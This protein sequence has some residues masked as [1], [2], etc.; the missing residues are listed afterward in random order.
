MIYF[1]KGG[2]KIRNMQESDI[3]A[4]SDEEI[5]Q[6]WSDTS[7]KYKMRIRDQ[8]AG[9]CVA[10]AAEFGGKIAGYINLYRNSEY[11]PFANHGIPEIIDFG[12]LEK[13]RRNGIGTALMDTAEKI[14]FSFSDLVCLCVGLHG[15]YGS[16]Q[17][18]YVKRGF[19]PDGSGVWYKDAPCKQN[20]IYRND[21][22]LVLYFSK[23]KEV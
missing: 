20:E 16:A 12:V 23:R 19:V 5:A 1:E 9:K 18:M 7:E 14:A 10:L 21:D 6:G 22:D 11:G 17:R 13:F 8:D 2:I 15:G 3:S 4:I